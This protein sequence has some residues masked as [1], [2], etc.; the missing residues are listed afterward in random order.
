MRKKAPRE[1]WLGGGANE[2]RLGLGAINKRA[3]GTKPKQSGIGSNRKRARGQ[4]KKEPKSSEA[5][6]PIQEALR[7]YERRCLLLFLRRYRRHRLRPSGRF[8]AGGNAS[9]IVG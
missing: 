5:E 1:R 3:L 2:A 4:L 8:R 6:G 9:A 7:F